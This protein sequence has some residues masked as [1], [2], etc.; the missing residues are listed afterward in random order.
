[1]QH[2][3]KPPIYR[4]III[5][6]TGIIWVAGLLAAGSDSPYMPWVNIGGL[7]V[8]WGCSIMLSRLLRPVQVKKAAKKKPYCFSFRKF[9]FSLS[10]RPKTNIEKNI[11]LMDKDFCG[12]GF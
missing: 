2:C 3:L 7:T 11:V 10:L 8:F 5:S 6:I 1:M 9:D 4:N 12:Q